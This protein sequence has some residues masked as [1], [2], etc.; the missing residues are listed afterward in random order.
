MKEHF[1]KMQKATP[2]DKSALRLFEA[3]LRAQN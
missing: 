3:Q 2:P 1:L